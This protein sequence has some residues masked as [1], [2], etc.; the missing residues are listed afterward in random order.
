[1]WRLPLSGLFYD[2]SHIAVIMKKFLLIFAGLL[3][4]SASGQGVAISGDDYD[5]VKVSNPDRGEGQIDGLIPGGFR[6]N[7]YTWRLAMRGDEIYIA[8]SRNL[9]N[10]VV[11]MFSPLMTAYGIST[12]TMWSIVDAV[13]NGDIPHNSATP[14]EGAQILSYNR[15][16]GDV[17]V[18]YTAERTIYFRMAVTFG[19]DVYFGT[20]SAYPNMPQYILKLDMDGKFTKVFETYGSVSM[21]AN[22]V[23]NDHLFFAGADAREEVDPSDTRTPCKMAVL[24]K[25]NEDDMQWDRVADYKDFGEYAY[26]PIMANTTGCPVWELAVH[27][28][29]I[30][31]SGPSTEGMTIFR[32]HPAAAGEQANEY[33]WYWEEVAGLNNGINNPGLSDI[34]GGEPDTYRSVL[35]SVFEFNGELYAFTFDHTVGCMQDAIVGMVSKIAGQPVKASDFLRHMYSTLTNPQKVWKLNDATGKFEECV[36]FTKLTEGTT[37]EYIWRM[38]VYEDELYI[39]TMDSGVCYGYLTQLTNGSF[40]NMSPEERAQKIEYINNLINILI[41][42]KTN[43]Y[44]ASL[45]EKLEQLRDFLEQY[46]DDAPVND[47]VLQMLANIENLI[48][49]LLRNLEDYLNGGNAPE[50]EYLA[51][52][53]LDGDNEALALANALAELANLPA[54]YFDNLYHNAKIQLSYNNPELIQNDMREGVRD[55]LDAIYEN[56]KQMLQDISDRIDVEGIKMYLYINRLVAEDEWGFDL[57]R[58]ADGVN[59]EVITRNGFGDKYNY[60]CPSFLETEEGLYIGTCNPFYGAQMF[61]LTGRKEADTGISSVKTDE[62]R[63]S[64]IYYTPNGLRLNHRPTEPGIYIN[65]GRKVVVTP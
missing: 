46:D 22:C 58:T 37:N 28:G 26:D 64:D 29:Y 33:G 55:V 32:G 53:I 18:L 24:M 65:D 20:Y 14:D 2:W 35:G 30:Y 13:T 8:T 39:S 52:G 11:N 25:S 45:I 40:F 36:N 1:M 31:A 51:Q 56:L 63:H 50:L 34:E 59:F 19:D 41:K 17:K 6:E 23:Y 43:E 12:E 9:A 3:A 5:V 44:V 48:D 54:N 60:G 57:F 4:L 21:R 49:Q 15:Q 7:S 10:G 47:T 62:T 16:T 42:F 38:G 27:N 61:L